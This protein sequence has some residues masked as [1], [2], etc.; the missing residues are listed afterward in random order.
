MINAYP[1]VKGIEFHRTQDTP[2]GWGHETLIVNLS[3][4][5]LSAGYCGKFLVYERNGALSSMHFHISKHETFYVFSGEFEFYYHNPKTG[6][7]LSRTLA[8]G[9]VVIIP[10]NNPHQ[11]FCKINGIIIEFSTKDK[12]ESDNFRIAG[13]DSQI[14][15]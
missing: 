4:L 3:D 9:D 7:K 15:S 11:L 6:E 10:P 14:K 13:G 8:A 1:I 2:K 12:G 5:N